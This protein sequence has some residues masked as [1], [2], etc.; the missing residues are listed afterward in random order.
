[1][2]DVRAMT[3]MTSEF[4]EI[5]G[6]G[7]PGFRPEDIPPP[8]SLASGSLLVFPVVY[9]PSETR[10]PGEIATIKAY[11][12]FGLS[13][14]HGNASLLD[15][16]FDPRH[17][18]LKKRH[19]AG[20]RWILMSPN[21]YRGESPKQAAWLARRHKLTLA[22]LEPLAASILIPSYVE[23]WQ[24]KNAA[25]YLTGIEFHL[26]HT[27]RQWHRTVFLVQGGDGKVNLVVGSNERRAPTF[28]SPTIR[29]VE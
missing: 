19:R 3:E 17:L 10:T 15:I 20:V 9:L 11:W 25:P 21:S 8:P 28:A 22:A 7:K 6:R 16:N 12:E 14:G 13:R 18:H 4:L 29:V 23:S 24:R 27:P 5:Y 2:P 26:D 1:M